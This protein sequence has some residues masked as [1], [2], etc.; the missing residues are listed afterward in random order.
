MKALLVLRLYSGCIQA[1]FRLY[2]GSIKAL[3]R[4]SIA[5]GAL[6]PLHSLQR[7]GKEDAGGAALNAAAGTLITPE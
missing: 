7:K 2:S 1:V 4:L 6:Q 3:L 5:T